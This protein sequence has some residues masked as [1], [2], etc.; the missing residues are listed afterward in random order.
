MIYHYLKVAL[1]NLWKYRT[2]SLISV[3]CLA[4]GITFYAVMSMYV[5]R[6]GFYRDQPDYERRVHIKK[7]VGWLT[8]EDWKQLKNIP[9]LEL[10]ELAVASYYDFK[11]EI[12]IIDRNQ[13]ETPYMAYYKMANESSFEAFALKKESGDIRMLNKDEVV[14]SRDFARK[15]FGKEDPLGMTLH[16]TPAIR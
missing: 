14:I 11:T 13:R 3:L 2:H 9:I 6:I 15:V 8:S 4:V 10:E 5:S 12:G 16:W 7:K 1:R